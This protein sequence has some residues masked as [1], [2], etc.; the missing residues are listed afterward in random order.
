MQNQNDSVR[1]LRLKVAYKLSQLICHEHFVPMY[2]RKCSYCENF[3]TNNAVGNKKRVLRVL[4]DFL[5]NTTNGSEPEKKKKIIDD[6]KSSVN[7]FN[8]TPT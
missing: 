4:N 8:D 5:I 2:G 7:T 6:P 3:N 1:D